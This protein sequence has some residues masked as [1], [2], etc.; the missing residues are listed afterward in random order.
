MVITGSICLTNLV[1]GPQ[2]NSGK[3]RGLNFPLSLSG[4][5]QVMELAISW[6]TDLF[7]TPMIGGPVMRSQLVGT[8]S[9][10]RYRSVSSCVFQALES[11][12]SNDH[13]HTGSEPLYYWNGPVN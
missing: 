12:S 6:D 7:P 9:F 10:L 4:P 8:F 11:L 1:P 5:I 13:S 3:I 2:I